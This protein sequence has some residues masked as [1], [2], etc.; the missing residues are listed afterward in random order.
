[1]ILSFCLAFIPKRRAL[2]ELL[3]VLGF[4]LNDHNL[5][6]SHHQ[7]PSVPNYVITHSRASCSLRPRSVLPDVFLRGF[8]QSLAH[9]SSR[10]QSP[11]VVCLR[12]VTALCCLP[13]G[14]TWSEA[15][16]TL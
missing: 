6:G 10:Q 7:T 1:M 5:P 12:Q 16:T 9:T 11:L 8:Y 4:V 2:L 15:L 14:L 3:A 13:E